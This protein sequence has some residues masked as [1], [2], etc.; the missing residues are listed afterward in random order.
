MNDIAT[1]TPPTR[2]SCR[3][4]Q[5]PATCRQ[6]SMAQ[7]M[8]WWSQ[9]LR[10][11]PVVALV[12]RPSPSEERPGRTVR[13]R[14]RL[15]LTAGSLLLLQILVAGCGTA[16]SPADAPTTT[17]DPASRGMT[18]TAPAEAPTPWPGSS[19]HADEGQAG[20]VEIGDG[21]TMYL[22]CR[23]VG[24]PTVVLIS[25]NLLAG[26]A[27]SYSGGSETDENDPPTVNDA[28]VFPT[29]ARYTRVCTYDRPGT[30]L[31]P[32]LDPS[33]SSPV[34]QPTTVQGDAA[35]LEALLAATDVPGPYV[36]VGHSLGGF[37][38]TMYARTFPDDVAGIVLVD[39]ASEFLATTLGPE[40][41]Q[42]WAAVLLAPPT[43]T[44]G[45]APDV[46]ASQLAIDALPPVPPVP[47][48]VL[49]AERWPFAFPSE[50][51]GEPE[52]HWDEWF[53]AQTLL[54]RSLD[55]THITETSSGH[56]VFIEN[57]AVVN[58]Q[59]CAVVGPAAEC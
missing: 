59:I 36:L 23:G 3:S 34:E 18:P 14:D 45:E 30:Q 8:R 6:M 57:A 56:N 15:V 22:E 1:P 55:A 40:A 31:Q 17:T 10:S 47:A 41:F 46:A 51:G 48:S 11:A 13:F 27:W 9:F 32:D 2:G 4:L 58:A 16:E 26:D 19:T 42:Q 35:D 21:R 49:S 7:P 50:D 53:A 33:R 37:I 52:D 12:A 39:G 24:S 54:A 5:G 20:L 43:D 29:T 44:G 25:G 38:A 28:A